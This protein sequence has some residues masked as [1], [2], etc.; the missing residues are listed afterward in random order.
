MLRPRTVGPGAEVSALDYTAAGI[1]VRDDLQEAHR[2]FLEHVRSPGTW[3]TGQER[4]AIAAET[5]QAVGCALCR[6]RKAA[7]SPRLVPGEHDGTGQLPANVVDVIHRVRTDPARLSKPWFEGVIAAGLGVAEYVELVAVVT[8]Q[9]GIDYFARALGVP[10]AAPPSP[11][12]GEPSRHLPA[13]A[14]PGEAWVP[15]IAVDEASGPEVD[16]YGG[17]AFVPNIVRA[18][19]L[20]P[21]EVR[22]LRTSSSAHYL[23]VE[24][25]ADPTVRRAL[26]RMQMELVAAR[27]SALNQCFY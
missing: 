12:P 13:A 27:V 8:M 10:P 16:L 22:A 1:P 26:D 25:I 7:L 4:L 14:R 9:T 21:A 2:S 18:L 20:V 11:L 24:Q 23:A 17:A 5:R 15:M 6:A 3:W 19:S